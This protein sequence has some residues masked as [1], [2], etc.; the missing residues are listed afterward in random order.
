MA[1]WVRGGW[2]GRSIRGLR[3]PFPAMAVFDP[4]EKYHVY[5]SRGVAIC[6]PSSSDC[7]HAQAGLSALTAIASVPA[8][9][10]P[11]LS[12]RL[13]EAGVERSCGGLLISCASSASIIWELNASRWRPAF[14]SQLLSAVDGEKSPVGDASYQPN[15]SVLKC[16][17]FAPHVK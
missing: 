3:V 16:L 1:V 6:G 17:C 13:A 11:L 4:I 12:A 14:S 9:K 2:F 5:L 7:A 15:L 10:I 8:A